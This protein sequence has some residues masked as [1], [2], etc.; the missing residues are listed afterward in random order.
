[1][2]LSGIK[3]IAFDADDTLWENEP[4]FREAERKAAEA[5]REYA[6]FQTISS[7]LYAV[8]VKN[9][10]DYGY[11]AKAFTLSMLEN[12]V[13]ISEGRLSGEQVARIIEAGREILHNPA[14]PLPGVRE[15]LSELRES[16]RFTMVVVTKGDLLDQRTKV[17]RSGLSDFFDLVEVVDEKTSNEYLSICSRLGSSPSELLSVGN[18]FK[19][20]IAPVLE[21]GG[22]GAHIPFHV[23]WQLEKV[24]EYDHPHLLR[25]SSIGE[26]PP[27][28]VPGS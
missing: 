4:R 2:D 25:L 1:M 10:P 28:L 18:S 7:S 27:L 15:T 24:E 16:G 26:L 12:A 11:G 19:S 6:D 9:M 14:V 17:A 5:I 21:I 8:E 20:D 3:V 23:L 13:K 22:F